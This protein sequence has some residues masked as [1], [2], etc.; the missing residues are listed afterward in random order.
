M[1]RGQRGDPTLSLDLDKGKPGAAAWLIV[2]PGTTG[3][4]RVPI[5]NSPISIG[6][7]PEA[8][9]CLEDPHVS[10]R[11]AEIRR[12]REG[13]FLRDLESRNGTQVDGIA[14]DGARLESGVTITLGTTALRFE[15]A[16]AWSE[17]ELP[18][19]APTRFG[20]A[21]GKSD[22]IRRVFALLA[23]IAP[24]D[25]TV[26]ILGETGTGKDVIARAIHDTSPRRSKPFGVFDCGAVAATLI[27]SELFGHEKGA[28]TGAISDHPGA[29]E[30]VNG[31]TLFLDEIGELALDLQPRL[32]RVLE[33]RRIARVGSV[34]DRPIDVRIV[35][36]TNRNLE[37][38]V[39]AGRFREDL[40]FRLSPAVV[41]LPPLRDRPG[42]L[43]DLV[44]AFAEQVRPGL[45]V[46]RDA[47]AVLASHDWPGNVRELRNVIEGAAAVSN[48]K[49]I[50]PKDLILF[51]KRRRVPTL[52]GL[53]LG[54]RTLESIERAAIR[55]TLEQVGGN[56]TK[57][58]QA[59]GIAPS[60]LY[61]KL[62]KYD[63]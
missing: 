26:T 61:A 38:E 14:V 36:A 3:E 33:Q 52:E 55:K 62:K 60:T 51:Q 16:S 41:L 37:A 43:P 25:L 44:V 46:S 18:A 21:F 6:K 22:T 47:V 49:V 2:A 8:D 30:R 11:H 7:D 34:E 15:T 54:G 29:F 58:A 63:L 42:D 27:E 20:A 45:Q 17:R 57:A 13:V 39:A 4:R 10:R 19:D 53:P 28:F 24:S 32:L 56:K 9:V 40:Y 12:T 48:A 23:R 5:G 50:E 31:G 35:A 59:L 1:S